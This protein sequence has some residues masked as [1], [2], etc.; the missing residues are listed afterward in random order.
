MSKYLQHN[1][2]SMNKCQWIMV[3]HKTLCGRSTKDHKF[4]LVHREKKIISKA[5][6]KCGCGTQSKFNVC[7]KNGCGYDKRKRTNKKM[8]KNIYNIHAGQVILKLKLH[9][10][11]LN[12]IELI[13]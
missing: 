2:T 13:E 8:R 5:C 12:K 9:K 4:C 11:L 10:E 1:I 3:G 6:E 7:R